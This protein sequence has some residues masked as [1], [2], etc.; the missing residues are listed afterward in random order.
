MLI[1]LTYPHAVEVRGEGWVEEVLC[2]LHWSAACV[3]VS[4]SVCILLQHSNL[5]LK[6]L[7][8]IITAEISHREELQS[9]ANIYITGN[10]M[11]CICTK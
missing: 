11:T 8:V 2:L 7:T 5:T 1:G 4:I 6:P 9:K 10:N 3:S